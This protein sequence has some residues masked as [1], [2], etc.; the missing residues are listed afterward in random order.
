MRLSEALSGFDSYSRQARIY[1]A[2]IAVLPV[3]LISALIRNNKPLVALTPILLSAGALFLASSIVRVLGQR[4]QQR[5]IVKWGGMPTTRLLRFCQAENQV[6]LQRRRQALEVLFRNPLP[7]RRQEA[8]NPQ[9]ADE[10][11][12]AAVRCLIT[13]VRSQPG[14]FTLIDRENAAYGFARNLLGV[15]PPALVALSVSAV[16]DAVIYLRDGLSDLLVV[17]AGLHLCLAAVWLFFIRPAWVRQAAETYAER[18]LEALDLP[19]EPP[20]R[21]QVGSADQAISPLGE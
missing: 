9:K 20:S 3:A 7:T 13:H 5:L 18:L 1:P 16:A 12:I 15:K 11:Y 4:A 14:R 8:A 21:E 2:M 17:V 19:L 10:V 6:M